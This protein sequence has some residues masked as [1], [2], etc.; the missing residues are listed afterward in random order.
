[1]SKGP[2][3]QF[4]THHYRHFNAAA[5][6]D[7]AFAQAEIENVQIMAMDSEQVSRQLSLTGTQTELTWQGQDYTF[8]LILVDPPRAGLDDV[9]RDL[10][11]RFAHVLYISCNPQT[12]ARDL[13]A[14]QTTHDI[15]QWAIFDQFPYTHHIEMG[16]Y[17]QRK[18]TDAC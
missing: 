6:V 15:Q 14:W 11:Q 8:D 18:E 2:V 12:L 3:S 10:V 13:A 1:M 16:V 7:A 5:L 17:L 9:T 4:I